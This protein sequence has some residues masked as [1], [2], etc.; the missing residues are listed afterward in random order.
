MASKKQT[1]KPEDET[2]PAEVNLETT[3]AAP[4][5]TGTEQT[6]KL[7]SAPDNTYAELVQVSEAVSAQTQIAEG[8]IVGD[9]VRYV[10]PNGKHRPAVVV[11]VWSQLTGVHEGLPIEGGLCNLQVFTDSSNDQ[12]ETQS[13]GYN[14][15]VASGLLWATS[16]RYSEDHVPGTW[17]WIEVG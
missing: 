7:T 12:D 2:K 10:M 5:V 9:T 14:E 1:P 16:V 15:R 11:E 8:V 13:S 6:Q 3:P 4:S 17:H